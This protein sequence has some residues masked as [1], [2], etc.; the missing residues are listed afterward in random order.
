[1]CAFHRTKITF[2]ADNTIAARELRHA[3]S[4]TMEHDWLRFCAAISDASRPNVACHD[5]FT[6]SSSG[7]TTVAGRLPIL[8]FEQKVLLPS[9]AAFGEIKLARGLQTMCWAYNP[10]HTG[11]LRVGV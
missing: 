8:T 10:T 3:L 4:K 1:V 7:P 6:H 5:H 2:S 9:Q 11:A